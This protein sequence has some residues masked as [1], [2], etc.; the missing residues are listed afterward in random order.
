MRYKV[1]F[2]LALAV[3]RWCSASPPEPLVRSV[4]KVQEVSGDRRLLLDYVRSVKKVQEVSGRRLDYS[5]EEEIVFSD[6]SLFGFFSV[7]RIDEGFRARNSYFIDYNFMFTVI[8]EADEELIRDDRYYETLD[9]GL[10]EC[11]EGVLCQEERAVVVIPA[12]ETVDFFSVRSR[13]SLLATALKEFSL[14]IR[15]FSVVASPWS[16][17]GN[18]LKTYDNTPLV[19]PMK[20]ST[21]VTQGYYGSWSHSDVAA[22]DVSCAEGEAIYAARDGVVWQVV[23]GYSEQCDTIDDPGACVASNQLA[24]KVYVAHCDGTSAVYAHFQGPNLIQVHVGQKVTARIDVLG[25][26]GSTGI[27]SGPHL[28]L[29]VEAAVL[30]SHREGDEEDDDAKDGRRGDIEDLGNEKINLSVESVTVETYVDDACDGKTEPF[31]PAKGQRWS[32][33]KCEGGYY[34]SGCEARSAKKTA[35]SKN[36]FLWPFCLFGFVSFVS[37]FLCARAQAKDATVSSRNNHLSTNIFLLMLAWYATCSD[38]YVKVELPWLFSAATLGVVLCLHAA[39][40]V[41]AYQKYRLHD[42]EWTQEHKCKVM[43][44]LFFA[45]PSLDGL[46]AI[47][48]FYPRFSSV[49]SFPND[50]LAAFSTLRI[51]L[52]D[53]PQLTLK[54][55]V[56]EASLANCLSAAASA[57][58]VVLLSARLLALLILLRRHNTPA[59]TKN[60]F[61]SGSSSECKDEYDRHGPL[62]VHTM[63]Y[64]APDYNADRPPS[65]DH[66]ASFDTTEMIILEE[67]LPQQQQ[68]DTG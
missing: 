6:E 51:F 36:D 38:F 17:W 18:P 54:L 13:S 31:V 12:Q 56:Y 15:R 43:V 65:F 35:T 3:P 5:E 66:P 27:S 34:V 16:K 60:F 23:S 68:E 14:S 47:L 22:L 59:P 52:I 32:S 33:D 9:R 40:S 61:P 20:T 67:V 42:F 2:W 19:P 10:V 49:H 4:K 48:P 62:F 39:I 50:L 64:S 44:A 28:H 25:F 37:C 53:L 24:N 46:S 8:V 41:V 57:L 21:V 11:E 55:M 58:L 45:L 1:F 63:M 29:Q 7:V 26:C 30:S